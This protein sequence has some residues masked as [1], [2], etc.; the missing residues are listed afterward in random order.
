MV[1]YYYYYYYYN[2]SHTDF[3]N[4]L[5]MRPLCF[6]QNDLQLTNSINQSEYV[7]CKATVPTEPYGSGMNVS[8]NYTAVSEQ[9][10]AHLL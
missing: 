9:I 1:Y 3:V 2:I 4:I 10:S 7:F 8:S 6:F 5:Y